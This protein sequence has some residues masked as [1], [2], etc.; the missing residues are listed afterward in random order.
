[1]IIPEEERLTWSEI[2]EIYAKQGLILY[3]GDAVG[4]F[5]YEW[6]ILEITTA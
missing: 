4:I 5:D 1:M 6:E 3:R 2:H